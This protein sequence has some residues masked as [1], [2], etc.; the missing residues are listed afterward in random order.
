MRL[1]EKKATD[2]S[3]LQRL[4]FDHAYN[5]SR[6]GQGFGLAALTL[7]L[8]FC[9]YIASLG[10][11]GPYIGGIL[12]AIDLVAIIATFMSIGRNGGDVAG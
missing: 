6:R 11:A 5:L 12:A 8:A 4:P 1:T 2:D 7:I 3:A 9:A 10:G